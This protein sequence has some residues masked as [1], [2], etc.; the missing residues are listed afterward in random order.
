MSTTWTSTRFGAVRKK[1]NESLVLSGRAGMDDAGAAAAEH[2][3][4]PP[5]ARFAATAPAP[6]DLR[7]QGAAPSPP[8][9][10]EVR[11]PARDAFRERPTDGGGGNNLKVALASRGGVDGKQRDPASIDPTSPNRGPLRDPCLAPVPPA[12]SLVDMRSPR[13]GGRTSKAER[14]DK[15]LAFMP[16]ASLKAMRGVADNWEAIASTLETVGLTPDLIRESKLSTSEVERL[17]QAFYVYTSGF[18]SLLEELFAAAPIRGALLHR[19]WASFVTLLENAQAGEVG[20][21]SAMVALERT[22]RDER[23]ALVAAAAAAEEEAV[24]VAARHAA[25]LSVEAVRCNSALSEL[26]T[27]RAR[28]DASSRDAERVRERLGEA[29]RTV[30]REEEARRLCEVSLDAQ[31]VRTSGL[32]KE[33]DAAKQ[34]Q[35]A[36]A[37]VEAEFEAAKVDLLHKATTIAELQQAE[38]RARAELRAVASDLQRLEPE[39]DSNHTLEREL[40]AA[41]ATLEADLGARGSELSANV[42]QV[43]TLRTEAQAQGDAGRAAMAGAKAAAGRLT[44]ERDDA[45]AAER[46]AQAESES[47]RALLTMKTNGLAAATERLDELSAR[48]SELTEE[49]MMQV[50][51]LVLT[52]RVPI[53]PR[54]PVEWRG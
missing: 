22:H 4:V 40:S 2:A 13:R 44:S 1:E 23:A 52:E 24:A 43:A 47:L 26:E 3:A 41:V 46:I 31:A 18:F 35:R 19:V 10:A 11:R 20:H 29:E 14:P 25:E 34:M 51:A 15:P 28:L 36:A 39:A 12:L 53:V 37:K 6:G 48:T 5:E 33:L 17:L 32:L 27:V 30:S 16:P 45:V 49:N 21:Q 42:A 9:P 7:S 54:L 50:R 38:R 8:M